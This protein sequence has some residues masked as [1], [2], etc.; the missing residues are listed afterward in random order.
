MTSNQ[1]STVRESK[2]I[3]V[4]HK[5]FNEDKERQRKSKKSQK[6]AKPVG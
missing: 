1:T 3:C 2:E 5:W 6:Q 4:Q